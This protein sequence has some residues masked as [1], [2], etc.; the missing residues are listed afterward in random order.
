MVDHSFTGTISSGI[1]CEI[2]REIDG[3]IELGSKQKQRLRVH[4]GRMFLFDFE[5]VPDSCLLPGG[6]NWFSRAAE[7]ISTNSLSPHTA[8]LSSVSQAALPLIGQHYPEGLRKSL[9]KSIQ[10]ASGMLS[11]STLSVAWLALSF[12]YIESLCS[13]AF[14]CFKVITSELPG[15]SRSPLT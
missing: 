13:S 1:C 11:P 7:D 12:S 3:I 6:L 14:L 15:Y 5:G 10:E 8:G 2:F 9:A 4:I